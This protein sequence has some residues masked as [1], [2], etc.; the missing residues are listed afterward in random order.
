MTE[1]IKNMTR[2]GYYVSGVECLQSLQEGLDS[3]Y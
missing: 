1:L 2:A 3:T